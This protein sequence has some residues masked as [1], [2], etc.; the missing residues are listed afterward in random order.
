MREKSDKKGLKH[1]TIYF[2]DSGYLKQIFLRI[3]EKTLVDFIRVRCLLFD[4]LYT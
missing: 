4:L 3:Q 2:S 1:I